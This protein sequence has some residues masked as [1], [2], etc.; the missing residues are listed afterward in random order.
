MAA[1]TSDIHLFWTSFST[2]NFVLSL[3][4]EI[5]LNYDVKSSGAQHVKI[6]LGFEGVK[7]KFECNSVA[8]SA[9][10]TLWRHLLQ[11]AF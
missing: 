11:P 7:T 8:L 9:V 6:V 3:E 5:R 4:L 1:F 2:L 10:E